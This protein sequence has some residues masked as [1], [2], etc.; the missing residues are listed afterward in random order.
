MVARKEVL[1]GS[2]GLEAGLKRFGLI[3]GICGPPSTSFSTRLLSFSRSL[4][5]RLSGEVDTNVV[6]VV[7]EV[8]VVGGSRSLTLVRSLMT[9]VNIM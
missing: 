9:G 7:L 4:S 3:S 5:P 2:L 8:L 6:V 1:K